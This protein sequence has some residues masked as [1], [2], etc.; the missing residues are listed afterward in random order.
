M[1]SKMYDIISGVAGERSR[2]CSGREPRWA[3]GGRV[4]LSNAIAQI[5]HRKIH[6]RL[7]CLMVETGYNSN[8]VEF[9]YNFAG[10]GYVTGKEPLR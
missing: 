4:K 7:I 3:E 5:Y 9:D 8:I 10:N 6:S 2:S 1:S